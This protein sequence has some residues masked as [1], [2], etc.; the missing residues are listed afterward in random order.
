MHE[1]EIILYYADQRP[2]GHGQ[3]ISHQRTTD[4]V[5]WSEPTIDA[6]YEDP[7][8]RPG[9][10]AVALLPDGTYIYV[11]EYGG[12]PAYDTYQFPVHYRI[13]ADPR[14][15]A[16]APD[17][18]VDA[19]GTAPFS[20]PFVVWTPWGGDNGTIVVSGSRSE[21]WANKALGD[22]AAWTV[23][24]TPHPGA[25]TR[26]LRIFE[27]KPELMIIMGA[28]V[29]PPSDDNVVSLSIVDLEEIIGSD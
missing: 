13:A 16:S 17:H 28:G 25:Y 24:N 7:E 20:S 18:P 11:Y 22:P 5:N 8:A 15:F 2:E 6:I 3:V 23:H 19:D 14:E 1:G 26:N 4:L 21:V 27:E 10:P 12:S 9:M 29:L